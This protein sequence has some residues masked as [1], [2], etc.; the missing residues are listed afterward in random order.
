MPAVVGVGVDDAIE[1][2]VTGAA[3]VLE[4]C[5]LGIYSAVAPGSAHG[6]GI[7]VSTADGVD[8]ATDDA[9]DSGDADTG[10][11]GGD[12]CVDCDG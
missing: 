11:S 7:E 10:V 9:C 6:S 5:S 4:T 8:L 12:G 3:A 1:D 2:V